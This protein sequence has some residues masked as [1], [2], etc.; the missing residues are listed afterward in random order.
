[1]KRLLL[2]LLGVL[3]L[4]S[5]LPERFFMLPGGSAA[6]LHFAVYLILGAG[7][8]LYRARYSFDWGALVLCIGIGAALEVG[9]LAVAG[10]EFRL[11]DLSLN[12]GGAVAG[13]AAAL[14]AGRKYRARKRPLENREGMTLAERLARMTE[15][16]DQ[17]QWLAAN[18]LIPV[19]GLLHERG[20]VPSKVHSLVA[21]FSERLGVVPDHQADEEAH[22][23]K[24][25]TRL[26]ERALLLKGALVARTFYPNQAQ[27]FRTDLDILVAVSDLDGVRAEL[28][29]QGYRRS[30]AVPLSAPLAQ[31]QWFKTVDGEQFAIDVHWALRNHPILRGI[32][33]FDEL[34]DARVPVRING[35]SAWGLCGAH[36]FLH[37]VMHWFDD[38]GQERPLAWLLDLDLIWRVMSSGERDALVLIAEQ[39]G[40]AGLA[41]ECL[42]ECQLVFG[43]P[44]ERA[45]L[46]R[47]RSRGEKQRASEL[48]GARKNKWSAYW[49]AFWSEPEWASKMRRLKWTFL[50]PADYVR[51]KYPGF[52]RK[53][54]LRA[55]LQRLVYGMRK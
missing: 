32:F 26:P 50:P 10:R 37:G 3:T 23:L 48:I 22:L 34:W 12:I 19:I 11:L 41:A 15:P 43:T 49:L 1:M 44:V 17:I 13:V 42:S 38:M 52:A 47:L 31:E 5:L 8:A 2:V 29:R 20:L 21:P 30:F 28:Q 25:L 51:A 46:D 45:L 9:Q 18:R 53:S 39:K 7:L 24:A 27:R 35:S 55:H 36:A 4:G 16:A 6:P 54:L 14:I 40:L 33:V